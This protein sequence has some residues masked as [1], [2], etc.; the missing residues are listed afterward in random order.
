MDKFPNPCYNTIMSQSTIPNRKD[1]PARD[2]WD[3]STLYK[4]DDDWEKALAEIPALTKKLTAFKG[5]LGISAQN[6]LGA[7]KAMEALDRTIE[8]TANYASLQHAAD[9]GDSAA[10]DREGRVMMAI[11]AA[12][13]ASSFFFPELM[14]IDDKTIAEWI[15]DHSFDDYRIFLSTQLRRK[16]EIDFVANQGS[17]RY[18]IQSAFSMP[19]SEKAYQEKR[20]LNAIKD[21]FKKIVVVGDISRPRRDDN[22]ILTIGI[23]TFMTRADSLEL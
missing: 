10:Q 12:E 1:V 18:Y 4:S 20:P 8:T 9:V 19:T 21:S 13:S 23:E 7:L 3:L 22:G 2:K 16:L 14:A 11:T 6:L 15:K 17:R 5:S